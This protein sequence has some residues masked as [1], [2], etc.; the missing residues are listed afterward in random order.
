MK[1]ELSNSWFGLYMYFFDNNKNTEYHQ[2]YSL[3]IYGS[4]LKKKRKYYR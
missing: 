1:E 3:R 2:P 4:I